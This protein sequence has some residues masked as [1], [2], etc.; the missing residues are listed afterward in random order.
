MKK[1]LF[2]NQN[3]WALGS[4]HHALA[5]ELY[6]YG[7]IANLLDWTQQYSLEEIRLTSILRDALSF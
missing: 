3:R 4:I 7:I 5:K 6:K 1:V 2:Y